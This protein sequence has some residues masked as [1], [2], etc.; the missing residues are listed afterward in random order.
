MPAPIAA[1][2]PPIK[3]PPTHRFAAGARILARDEE[4]LVRS[5]RQ[6][7]FGATSVHV[8]GISELVRGHEA[9]FLSDLDDLVELKPEE[10][11]LVQDD[12]PQYRKSRLYLESL[13]RK[14]QPTEPHLVMGHLGAMDVKD[15]QLVPAARALQQPRARI[16]IAD[17]VGLG[18]TIETGILL[19]ELI[20]RGRGNR[21]L[22]VA[23]KSVLEQFQEELWARFTIPLVRLDS[24]GIERVRR[25]IPANMNPFQKFDRVIISVD[26][27]KKDAKYRRFLEA[28][29]WDVTVIDECQHV[30]VRVGS[31]ALGKTASKGALKAGVSQRARLAKLLAGTCDSLILTSATP[32]DGKP[33]SFASLINLLEPTAVANESDY[34]ADEIRGLYV[35][36]FKKDIAA[37]AGD[38][39]SERKVHAHHIPATPAED[40]VLEGLRAAQFKTLRARG[41]G[42]GVLFR[43][44][45]LKGYLSSPEALGSSID[46]R[47]KRVDLRA[48]QQDDDGATPSGP[49]ALSPEDLA[50]D[51]ALLNDLAALTKQSP[52]PKSGKFQKL[53]E[54][55]KDFGVADAARDERVV[56]FSE[57]IQTLSMLERELRKATGLPKDAIGTFHG[58]LDDQQQQALVKDFGTQ[59]S[60]LRVLLCSDAASEGINLHYH[61]HRMVHYDIPWSL[62]TLEQRNGRIDRFGQH[63]TPDIHYLFTRP[64]SEALKGDLRILEVLTEKEHRAHKNLGDVQWLMNLHDPEAEAD[65]VAAAISQGEDP[66]SFIR[67]PDALARGEHTG[68]ADDDDEDLTGFLSMLS[69]GERQ[70]KSAPSAHVKAATPF[71]VYSS[72]IGFVRDALEE[73][74]TAAT[75]G[76]EVPNATWH[77]EAE[78]LTLSAPADLQRRLELM[79]PELRR[80]GEF[81]FKLTSSR[82]LVQQALT[83]SRR[84]PSRW[85]EWQLLWQ[86]HPVMEW[87]NDR[88]LAH[89]GR[90]EAP[91][92]RVHDGL[93]AGEAAFVFQAVL[94]NQQSQPMVLDW[95]A[96]RFAD[97][98]QTSPEALA[99]HPPTV[100]PFEPL[101]LAVKLHQPLSNA[102]KALDTS[103]LL[104]LRSA[105]VAA[106]TRHM[107]AVR[108]ERGKALLP[109]IK[110]EQQRVAA[111]A[112]RVTHTLAQQDQALAARGLKPDSPQRL[113]LARRSADAERELSDRKR[114]VEERF[115]T[116]AEPY[117]RLALVLKGAR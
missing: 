41:A 45:L 37:E 101:A 21:I 14:S 81:R 43:T 86:Q 117:L 13:L 94:S 68:A 96:V 29:H 55:L 92:L 3:P 54:L 57:R 60:P 1:A 38:S 114:W 62:I 80:D 70:L 35:R 104:L 110:A 90:H 48:Q 75:A 61:C 74:K 6:T 79:P 77:L 25:N 72:S 88:V 39:F 87:L 53:L 47:T 99:K 2:R 69:A 58:S 42:H 9:V 18:K 67:D 49:R 109:T 22:V 51:R 76:A 17:A 73:L 105:A 98:T 46:E 85:P 106:A 82:A 11:L 8:T 112:E 7:R 83:D 95:L 113:E 20:A 24:V 71:S 78:G 26:T 5:A 65:R 89:F 33:E 66:D 91:V 84:D 63:H 64:S 44:T 36:R 111:W 32:H 102:G 27:L 10:T 31:S 59:R 34:T 115:T 40:A 4:W 15:Y 52:S 56:I 28:C 108:K 16:L 30:A 97:T 107:Q 50:H 12:S 93:H 23:L 100:E 19:S 116:G 103:R